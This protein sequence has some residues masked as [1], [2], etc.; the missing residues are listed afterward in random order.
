[1][2][3]SKVWKKHSSKNI[4]ERQ[5]FNIRLDDIENLKT[6]ARLE[7]TVMEATNSV[8][9]VPVTKEGSIVFARQHRFGIGQETIELPGGIIEKGEDPED[10]AKRELAEETGF[11]SSHWVSLG[12]SASNPVYNDSYIYHYLAIDVTQSTQKRFDDG[13]F[14]ENEMYTLDQVKHMIGE[15]KF[16]H[17]HTLSALVKYLFTELP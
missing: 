2:D 5:L 17:P 8:N 1:V 13:E 14:I 7:I 15:G 9:V 10:A 4:L 11:E 3:T 16:M 12:R 6:G